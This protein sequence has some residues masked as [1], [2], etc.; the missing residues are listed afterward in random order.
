MI[1]GLLVGY[2]E[3]PL[4]SLLASQGPLAYA[5]RG[6][7]G[8]GKRAALTYMGNREGT[9]S[10][11]RVSDSVRT[12]ADISV[13]SHKILPPLLNNKF[14]LYGSQKHASHSSFLRLAQSLMLHLIGWD[15]SSLIL[16]LLA[17][18]S[19]IRVVIAPNLVN[20]AAYLM[21]SNLSFSFKL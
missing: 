3:E 9:P 6:R 4:H 1:V 12:Y 18:G 17:Q 7:G 21:N 10:R 2:Q 20:Y 11:G 8:P 13:V 5:G 16:R 14:N 15:H 19:R